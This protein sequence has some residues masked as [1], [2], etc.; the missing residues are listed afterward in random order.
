[1]SSAFNKALTRVMVFLTQLLHMS[2]WTVQQIK[3][4]APLRAVLSAPSLH[5]GCSAPVG[6]GSVYIPNSQGANRGS[7]LQPWALSQ[8]LIS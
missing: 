5:K 4:T 8:F 7:W 2:T 6:G 3:A 1:M